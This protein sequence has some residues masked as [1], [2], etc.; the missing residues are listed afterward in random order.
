MREKGLVTVAVLAYN[1]EPYVRQCL[2]SVV[3]Q[4]HHALEV[5]FIDDGSSD[6]TYELGREFLVKSGVRHVAL[7][8]KDRFICANLNL[9]LKEYAKGEYFAVISGDDWW[10]PENIAKKARFLE[11]H[12]DHPLV[13]SRVDYYY[14][15]TGCSEPM[16]KHY[17]DGSIFERLLQDNFIAAHSALIRTA[18]FEEVGYYDESSKVEDWDMWLRIAKSNPIGFIDERL[19]YYRIH[20]KNMSGCEKLML[21]SMIYILCKHPDSELARVRSRKLIIQHGVLYAPFSEALNAFA[22]H[23]ACDMHSIRQFIKLFVRGIRST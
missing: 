6:R 13:Y 5:V 19:G 21:E 14:Q 12:P 22:H 9:I 8:T 4:T 7:Q 20:D 18:I 23:G 3:G 10:A 11:S 15:K 17:A 16:R 1:H 2:E